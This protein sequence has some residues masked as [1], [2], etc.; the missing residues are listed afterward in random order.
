M[1]KSFVLDAIIGLWLQDVNAFGEYA[2]CWIASREGWHAEA[3]HKQC[4]G[5]TDTVVLAM[6]HYNRTFGAYMDVPWSA[7]K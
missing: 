5:L 1:L 4:D 7:S 2:P 6:D 3:F